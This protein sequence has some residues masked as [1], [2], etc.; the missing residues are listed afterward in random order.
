MR[1]RVF[2]LSLVFLLLINVNLLALDKLV[3]APTA[4]LMGGKGFI[5]GEIIGSSRRQV[6]GLYNISSSLALGGT[7]HFNRHNTE[8]GILAK[9]IIVQE[10]EVQPAVAIGLQKEDLYIVA[11]K[12]LGLGF[13]GHFGFGNGE[14]GGLFIGFN[15][16]LNPVSI[17]SG[18][19]SS[20]PIINLK[21]E[22]KNS[23]VSFAVQMN[24][25]ENMKVDIGFVGL[26]EIKL[27]LG[28]LF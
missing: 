15:K 6:S 10:D 13:R 17:N 16:F 2:L 23:E 20:L 3:L 27:G 18:T 12:N 25:Q 8:P 21:G 4:D 24:L 1:R 7:I 11:S 14:L 19:G 22:Y 5:S 9:L 28:Y 26:E